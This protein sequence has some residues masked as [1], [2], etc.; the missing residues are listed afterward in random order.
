MKPITT[1]LST[2]RTIIFCAFLLSLGQVQVLSEE[3]QEIGLSE[4]IALGVKNNPRLISLRGAITIAEA[5]KKTAKA[6][7]DPQ[8]RFRKNW[9][10]SVIPSPFSETRTESFSEQ[11]TRTEVNADGQEKKTISEENV[12]RNITRTVTEGRSKTVTE[13]VIE[14]QSQENITILPNPEIFEPGGVKTDNRDSIRTGTRTDFHET[15]PYADE[16]EIQLQFRLY[17]PHPVIRKARLKKAEQEI[18]LARETA[19]AE[20]NS[21]ILNVR[22]EYEQLQHLKAR[23]EIIKMEHEAALSYS[24]NQSRLLNSGLITIDKVEYVDSD[25][26][27]VDAAELEYMA[28]RDKIAAMVGLRE[29]EQIRVTDEIISPTVDLDQTHLE[30]LIRMALTNRGELLVIKKKEEIAQTSL[31]ASKA[32]L[33]PWFDYV[34]AGVSREEEGGQRTGDNWGVQLA[35]SIPIFSWMNSESSIQE[36]ALTSYYS[37]KG[38]TQKIITSEVVAAYQNLKRAKSYREKTRTHAQIQQKYNADFIEKIGNTNR[39]KAEKIRFEIS[40]N[41]AKTNEHKLDAERAYNKALMQ[42]EKSLGSPLGKVF[43]NSEQKEFV[44]RK[45]LGLEQKTN[46]KNLEALSSKKKWK[47]PFVKKLRPGFK[48]SSSKSKSKE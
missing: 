3:K 10:S 18:Q 47:F 32:K 7:R 6:W 12:S 27:A 38:A 13:E 41:T 43:T 48:S 34:Q 4:L 35:M 44:P 42:L 39:N 26:I 36:A 31:S 1:E 33:I 40:R 5:R 46:G 9:G 14:E 28:Q 37:Q 21:V 17:V 15:D 24:R 16:S 2:L 11:V 22:E 30:Y 8:I 29:S 20:E 23:I 25:G 19:T 45:N